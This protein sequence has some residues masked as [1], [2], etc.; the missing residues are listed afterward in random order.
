MAR[1]TV[2]ISLSVFW[3]FLC[4]KS[5]HKTHESPNIHFE[6]TEYNPNSVLGVGRYSLIFLLQRLGFFMNIKKSVLQPCEKIEFL[7]IIV[8]LKE[9]TLSFP[10]KEGNSNYGAVSNFS[11][12]KPG[13]P[14]RNLSTNREAVLHSY[15]QKSF[16]LNSTI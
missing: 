12:K 10:P 1:K 13:L 2:P 3:P 11:F 6:E 15:C 9:M 7:G 14:E 8:D 5:F 16:Q 4:T